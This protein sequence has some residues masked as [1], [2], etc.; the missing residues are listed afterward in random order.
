QSSGADAHWGGHGMVPCWSRRAAGGPVARRAAHCGTVANH[1]GAR[2]TAAPGFSVRRTVAW[3]H[4]AHTRTARR[5]LASG[6]AM[7]RD[8]AGTQA[9]LLRPGL[10]GSVF[11]PPDSAAH[12]HAQT[13]TGTGRD[14]TARPQMLARCNRA[15]PR[16]TCTVPVAP[17]ELVT[18]TRSHRT[19]PAPVHVLHTGF[20]QPG[21]GPDFAPASHLMSQRSAPHG[22]LWAPQGLHQPPQRAKGVGCECAGRY[23][24]AAWRAARENKSPAALAL[25]GLRIVVL[26]T[27]AQ[28]TAKRR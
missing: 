25:P 16:P 1:T 6:L 20:W 22:Q 14:M 15:H 27:C 12:G 4:A 3:L 17:P 28:L 23:Q 8:E 11:L 13:R 18:H 21:C 10:R 24:R 19:V 2:R 5:M 9:L 26:R 7:S